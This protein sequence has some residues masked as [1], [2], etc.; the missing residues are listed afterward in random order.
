M[1]PA[2]D[3]DGAFFLTCGDEVNFAF[4]FDVSS[5]LAGPQPSTPICPDCPLMIT[6]TQTTATLKL[7]GDYGLAAP[8]ELTSGTLTVVE[9]VTKTM[10]DVEAFVALDV[11]RLGQPVTLRLPHHPQ[12]TSA[13]VSF[14][15]VEDSGDSYFRSSQLRLTR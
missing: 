15:V 6:Q 10:Y 2:P 5:F 8:L 7:H 1:Y 11:L 9:G 4:P 13:I 3:P 12:A 14:A